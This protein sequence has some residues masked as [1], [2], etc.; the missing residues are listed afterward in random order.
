MGNHVPRKENG[1][2]V[3]LVAGAIPRY[4]IRMAI[5]VFFI[6]DVEKIYVFCAF[7]IHISSKLILLFEFATEGFQQS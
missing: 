7:R 1:T 2:N 4:E 3:K 5:A 6:C